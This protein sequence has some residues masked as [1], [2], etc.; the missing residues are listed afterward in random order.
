MNLRFVEAFVWVARLNSISRAAEKL[1]LT[2]SAV[3]NRIAMLEQELGALLLDRRN[4]GFRLTNAGVRFLNYADRFL[5]LQLELKNELGGAEQHPFSLRLGCNETALHTWLIPMLSRLKKAMPRI[6]FDLTI[7]TT[8]TL[9]E[10]IRRGG[11]DLVFSVMPAIGNGIINEVLPPFE[12]VFIGPANMARQPEL[13]IGQ[14]LA[15]EIM[16]FQRGSQPHVALMEKLRAHGAGHKRVHTLSSISAL[17]RLAE[18][19]LGI[20]TLPLA[21]AKEL[22]SKNKIIILRSEFVLTPLPMHASY[23]DSSSAP[24]LNQAVEEALEFARNFN[25]VE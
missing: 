17:I 6:D 24:A 16:T 3:S 21:T 12:M 1:C 8:P 19:G 23:W 5:E 14:V 7:E 9:N 18:S 2:Q 13:N 15:Q 20:A 25:P 4:Q 22:S 10:Q 11:Q